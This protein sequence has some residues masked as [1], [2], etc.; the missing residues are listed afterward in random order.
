MPKITALKEGISF[1]TLDFDDILH[2]GQKERGNHLVINDKEIAKRHATLRLLNN[3]YYI[4]DRGAPKG[5][6]LDDKRVKAKKIVDGELYQLS[7]RFSIEIE[8]ETL[9][10]TLDDEL[11]EEDEFSTIIPVHNAHLVVVEGPML[12]RKFQLD[13]DLII[14]GRHKCSDILLQDDDP[15]IEAGYS[16]QHVEIH[17][18]D[19]EF[20]LEVLSENGIVMEGMKY[21][22]GY[23]YCLKHNNA[24]TIGSITFRFENPQKV[25]S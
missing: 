11:A 4:I 24:F 17:K 22:E 6:F 5:I 23:E 21:D 20:I 10:S 16:R 1:A 18:Q 12:G 7:P 15:E 9:T 13:Q 8:M 3:R 19:E 14:I 2:I 25:L